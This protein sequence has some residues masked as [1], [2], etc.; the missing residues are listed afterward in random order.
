MVASVAGISDVLEGLA[1]V[2]GSGD[3]VIVVADVQDAIRMASTR[4]IKQ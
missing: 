1:V 2:V 4:S 3:V